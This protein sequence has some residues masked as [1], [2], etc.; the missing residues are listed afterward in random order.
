MSANYSLWANSGLS[1][2]FVNKVLL[3]R[4]HACSLTYCARC[5]LATAADLNGCNRGDTCLAKLGVFLV[6]LFIGSWLT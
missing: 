2:T 3:I 6:Q 1:F 4:S 5:F